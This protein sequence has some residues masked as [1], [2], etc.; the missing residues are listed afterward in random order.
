MKFFS[1]WFLWSQLILS[2]FRVR[3]SKGSVI[4]VIGK[5]NLNWLFRT[6]M[7]DGSIILV[8]WVKYDIGVA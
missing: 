4:Y 5:T 8:I 3:M 2:A 1:V 7:D 6:R